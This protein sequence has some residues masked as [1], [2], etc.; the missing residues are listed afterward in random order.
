ML[1]EE[2][3]GRGED[4]LRSGVQPLGLLVDEPEVLVHRTPGRRG[5]PFP[6]A[7][8]GRLVVA[9]P[10]DVVDVAE[11]GDQGG[12]ADPLHPRVVAGR[13]GDVVGVGERGLP[14]LNRVDLAGIT[15]LC[16]VA[17]QHHRT[18]GERGEPVADDDLRDLAPHEVVR[19]QQVLAGV[20]AVEDVEHVLAVG[21]RDHLLEAE[22][23]DVDVEH[24]RP[25]RREVVATGEDEA[26]ATGEESRRHAGCVDALTGSASAREHVRARRLLVQPHPDQQDVADREVVDRDVG[27]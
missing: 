16:L 26:L 25:G 10:D 27:E 11:P 8:G 14:P 7:C 13:V 20:D 3:A 17:E 23:V 19:H 6:R 12:V 2:L 22:S 9:E 24:P 1:V 21:C 4:F 18:V 5:Q 15:V